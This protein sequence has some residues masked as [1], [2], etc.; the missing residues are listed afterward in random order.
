MVL[1]QPATDLVLESVVT[2]V[3][4]TY[5]WDQEA[6]CNLI[7]ETPAADSATMNAYAK[8]AVI[9]M[10]LIHVDSRNFVDDVEATSDSLDGNAQRLDDFFMTYL[11]PVNFDHVDSMLVD[12]KDLFID[13]TYTEMKNEW[14]AIKHNYQED[15]DSL[16]STV[17]TMI[18]AQFDHLD[19]I[20]DDFSAIQDSGVGFELSVQILGAKSEDVMVL[21]E[22][23]FYN[24]DSLMQYTMDGIESFS[25]AMEQLD[26]LQ[27]NEISSAEVI[28]SFQ[29]AVDNLHDGMDKLESLLTTEPLSVLQTDTSFIGEV[30]NILDAADSLLAGEQY[31][32]GKEDKT[33]RPLALLENSIEDLW[34]SLNDFY[35]SEDRYNYTFNNLF[36]LGLPM[37]VV[38][39]LGENM[40][41]NDYDT[42]E[43]MDARMEELKAE[44]LG[45]LNSDPTNSEAHFGLAYTMTYLHTKN[46][47]F[48]LEDFI[49]YMDAADFR[50][51]FDWVQFKNSAVADSIT[52][53]FEQAQMDEDLVFTVLMLT[54]GVEGYDIT[55]GR[56]Y[57]PIFILKPHLEIIKGLAETAEEVRNT[58][59]DVFENIYSE[60]DSMFVLDL[61]PNYLDFSTAET[62]MDYLNIL[63]QSNPNFLDITP[64]GVQ[65]F[66][67]AREELRKAFSRYT[68]TAGYFEELIHAMAE[69]EED[70]GIDGQTMSDF[71]S[72]MYG[73]I[74]AKNTDF[75]YPDSAIYIDEH[76][77]LSA[78]FDNPPDRLLQ[79]LKWY[80]DDDE[81]TDNTLGGLFPDRGFGTAIVN[82]EDIIPDK[83]NLAQNYPNPFNPQTTIEYSIPKAGKVVISIYNILG[84]HM[85]TI[86]DAQQNAGIYK[87]RWNAAKLPAGLY[88]YK[89][90][91]GDF[92][93][94]KKCL[95]VK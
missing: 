26:S 24:M 67:E 23:D 86:L 36:P 37:E 34:Q 60:L 85:D 72:G 8:R 41:I 51:D 25:R 30:N 28:A 68:R 53:H 88:F 43:E 58:L 27:N 78:W 81:N 15:F 82:P 50:Q 19:T 49:A 61:D 87:I 18:E 90:Q 9:H 54:D 20:M 7:L 70:L 80:F 3:Y 38:D 45:I 83:Y 62:E 92:T 48:E 74:D 66:E 12:L 79:R 5:L 22:N 93:E 46:L 2:P 47:I 4:E 29:D 42:D 13:P 76:V 95:L 73:I 32:L 71:A 63:E 40:V 33:I 89:I 84:Q 65:K 14:D 16:G 39:R 56:E 55:S 91:A 75:Q 77:N 1:A 11:D 69:H 52:H 35:L 17:E 59:T 21:H 94:V 64:Y 10:A 57:Q 31:D 44:Y 6:Q